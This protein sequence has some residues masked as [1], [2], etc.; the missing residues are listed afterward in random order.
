MSKDPVSRP[1]ITEAMESFGN[2]K[3]ALHQSL[4]PLC[5]Q[6]DISVQQLHI[7]RLINR[8]ADGMT[9]TQLAD[10]AQITPG[11]I[12]QFVDQLADKGF[13]RRALD[14]TDR[15][16][17]IISIAPEAAD[18]MSVLQTAQRE[19]L[20]NLFSC[21]S[22]EELSIFITLLKKVDRHIKLDI[23]E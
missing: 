16:V 20:E 2:F 22:D 3:H 15:R 13:I 9:T 6:Y 8:H 17:T 18:R 10:M 1:N 4:A 23:T 19:L 11:A 14:T 21:L 12:S 7:L 5:K